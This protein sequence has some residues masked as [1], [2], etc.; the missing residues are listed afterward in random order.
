ME[1]PVQRVR[2]TRRRGCEGGLNCEMKMALPLSE[3]RDGRERERKK[4]REREKEK[5]EGK[6][7]R[8]KEDQ[9]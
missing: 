5:R 8:R 9:G 7:D 2:A 6:E 4:M 1:Y 3:Q